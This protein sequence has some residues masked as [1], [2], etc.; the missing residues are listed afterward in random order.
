[1]NT[2]FGA[3]DLTLP[4]RANEPWTLPTRNMLETDKN[5]GKGRNKADK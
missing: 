2:H 3:C 4:A 1:M 5:A